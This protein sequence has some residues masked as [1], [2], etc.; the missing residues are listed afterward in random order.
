MEQVIDDARSRIAEL[1]RENERLRAA[2][3]QAKSWLRRNANAEQD[4]KAREALIEAS[5]A[6]Q[7][8]LEH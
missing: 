2:M 4:S 5:N 3:D 8:I 6:V 7:G 1:A